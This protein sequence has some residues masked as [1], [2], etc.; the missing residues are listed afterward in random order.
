MPR[1]QYVR[2]PSAPSSHPPSSPSGFKILKAA[3][4]SQADPIDTVVDEIR[5]LLQARVAES[6]ATTERLQGILKS[7]PE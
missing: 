1:G 3:L 6:Q 5:Q 7:L 4:K 2:K